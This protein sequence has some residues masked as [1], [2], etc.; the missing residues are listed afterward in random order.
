MTLRISENKPHSNKNDISSNWQRVNI[1]RV[2]L[3]S[4]AQSQCV[5]GLD[6]WYRL[7]Y[8]LDIQ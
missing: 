5:A 8:H 3:K 2:G 7:V 4:S 6:P 1:S